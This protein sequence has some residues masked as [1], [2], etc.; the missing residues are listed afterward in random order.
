MKLHTNKEYLKKRY[1]MQ[2]KTPDEI[3]KECNVT[4]QTIYTQLKKFGL[5]K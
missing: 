4:V 1:V 5:R 3:A 2:K